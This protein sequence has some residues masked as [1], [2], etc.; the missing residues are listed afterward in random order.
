M[1]T[2]TGTSSTPVST[3]ARWRPCRASGDFV[4]DVAALAEN[5]GAGASPDLARSPD[6]HLLPGAK[7]RSNHDVRGIAW[8]AALC[9]RITAAMPNG[10]NPWE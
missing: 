8:L 7:P 3:I 9:I 1:R 10:S 4:I 5:G 2:M 6:G